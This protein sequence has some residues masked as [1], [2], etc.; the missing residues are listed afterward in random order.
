MNKSKAI[1]ILKKQ[2]VKL[3]SADEYISSWIIQTNSYLEMIFGLKS[4]QSNFFRNGFFDIQIWDKADAT[5]DDIDDE[6]KRITL[7]KKSIAVNF[8]NECIDLIDDIGVYKPE[9]K[10]N[11]ISRLSDNMITFWL[12]I[13]FSGGLLIGRMVYKIFECA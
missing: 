8:L 10:G 9:P 5:D 6:F 12:G 13:I 4:K 3:E 11:Y 1:K 7:N 2:I